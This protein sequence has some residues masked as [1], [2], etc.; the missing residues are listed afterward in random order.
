MIKGLVF[1]N[2]FIFKYVKSFRN[3]IHSWTTRNMQITK[4]GSGATFKEVRIPIEYG[5]LAAKEYGCASGKKLIALHGWQDNAGSFDPLI[6]HLSTD[7][8][9]VAVDRAGHGLSS[10]KPL[11]H[12]YYFWDYINQIK[13]VADFY[14]WKEFSMLTHSVAYTLAVLFAGVYPQSVRKVIGLDDVL[15]NTMYSSEL[16]PEV[17]KNNIYRFIELEEKLNNEPPA[18]SIDEAVKLLIKGTYN[19]LTEEGAKV[20]MKRGVK[21]LENGKVVFSRDIRVKNVWDNG[22]LCRDITKTI[23]SNV[24]CDVLLIKGTESSYTTNENVNELL[25]IYKAK[26]PTFEMVKLEGNHYV[27]FCNPQ[28]VASLVNSFMFDLNIKDSL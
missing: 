6:P 18:Y 5:H 26:C 24:K 14:N 8:H 9:I 20:L 17:T 25:E 27:H 23:I 19:D 1:K 12:P 22:L 10:H 3:G 28:L 16:M 13:I 15:S 11:G 2:S 21:P 4:M 7:L